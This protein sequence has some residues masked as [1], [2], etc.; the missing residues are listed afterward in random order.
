MKIFVFAALVF[1]CMA[2]ALQVF[3]VE[4]LDTSAAR[5]HIPAP[6]LSL[7]DVIHA[8]AHKHQIPSSLVKSIIAAESSFT[9]DVVSPKG[10]IGL[11]Q[12]MPETARELGADPTVPE[13]NVDAGAQYLS[14]LLRRFAANRNPLRD[15]VAAYN[16]GPGAV[17]RYHGVPPYR[18]TRAYVARVLRFF[19]RYEK[20]EAGPASPRK[21]R[22]LLV[23]SAQHAERRRGRR[24]YSRTEKALS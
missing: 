22:S 2:P 11:M 19:D 17:E 21:R 12:L 14:R 16:A 15:A 20:L 3:T 9:A 7:D 13:Q 8:A 1:V 24:F 4:I 23:A 6:T 10:A 5:L 18:E